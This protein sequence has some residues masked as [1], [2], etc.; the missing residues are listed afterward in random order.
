MV[1]YRA[2]RKARTYVTYRVFSFDGT[3]RVR[4]KGRGISVSVVVRGS[5]ALAGVDTGRTGTYSIAGGDFLS[6]PRRLHTFSLAR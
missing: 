1:R 2:V 6:R 4:V 3:W 5:L